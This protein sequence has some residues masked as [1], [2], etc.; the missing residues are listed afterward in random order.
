[1]VLSGQTIR[2]LA[3]D[4]GLISPFLDLGTPAMERVSGGVSLA[5]YDIRLGPVFKTLKSSQ[6]IFSLKDPR[7]LEHEFERTEVTTYENAESVY[8]T[9][10]SYVFLLPARSFVLASSI[11]YFQM[12]L[13]LVGTAMDKSTIARSGIITNVTPLEPGWNGYLT[14][15][16]CNQTD[17][18]EVLFIG[19]GIVQVVFHWL[20]LPVESGY[21]RTGVYQNQPP[22]PV[23]PRIRGIG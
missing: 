16:I 14:I 15:E 2:R 5:G 1:M 19:E 12:P 17:R 3:R 11:E 22:E 9:N 7:G 6:A 10:D 21:G 13:N 23:V 8:R 20:D 4:E 18:D